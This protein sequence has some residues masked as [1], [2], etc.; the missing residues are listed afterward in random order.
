MAR[1]LDIACPA[2]PGKI[3]AVPA[4]RERDQ[5]V[6]QRHVAVPF[7]QTVRPIGTRAIAALAGDPAEPVTRKIRNDIGTAAGHGL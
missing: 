5:H 6:G 3:A 1:R 4:G 7:Q 2:W